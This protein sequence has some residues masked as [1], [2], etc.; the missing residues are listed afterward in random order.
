MSFSVFLLH[1]PACLP[2]QSRTWF[3]DF[4]FFSF[5]FSFLSSIPLYSSC[6]SSLAC[7]RAVSRSPSRFPHR[8]FTPPHVLTTPSPHPLH[9]HLTNFYASFSNVG[10]LKLY[11]SFPCAIH[12]SSYLFRSHHAWAEHYADDFHG[13]HIKVRTVCMPPSKRLFYVLAC[14]V[15]VPYRPCYY[16]NVIRVVFRV[17]SF[18]RA[19]H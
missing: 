8:Y 16:N 18:V 13:C 11:L 9:L 3:V 7:T 12:S 1:L 4:L 17:R 6:T 5:W 15:P 14:R 19:A 2:Y 10:T